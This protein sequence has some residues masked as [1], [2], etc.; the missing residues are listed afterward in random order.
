MSDDILLV[1]LTENT[2]LYAGIVALLP[3]VCC[4]RMDFGARLLPL[5]SGG[6]R[7]VFIA[8]DSQIFFRGEWGAFNRLKDWQPDASVVWLTRKETGLVLPQDN[9]KGRILLLA[10]QT[11]IISFSCRLREILQCSESQYGDSS[12]QSIPVPVRLTPIEQ[13]LLSY[14]LTGRSIPELSQFTGRSVKTL[15][16]YRLSI[17][18]KTGFRHASFLQLVYERNQCL[19][20]IKG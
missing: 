8:V 10:Q 5:K 9:F 14:F 16:H 15:Y 18:K 7:Q 11:D 6:G 3:E 13:R 2:W 12:E 1:V 19:L 17:M 4:H 20:D